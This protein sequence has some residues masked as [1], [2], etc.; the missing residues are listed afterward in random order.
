MTIPNIIHFLFFGFTDFE[1]FHYLAIATAYHVQKPEKI[2]LYNQKEPENN[3]YW[4]AIKPY[5][6]LIKI[7]PPTDFRGIKLESYQYKADIVRM[8]KLLEH[9]GIYLDIDVMV[10][11][12]FHHLLEHSC[13]VGAES[14]PSDTTNI[15]EIGSI[16]NAVLMCEPEHPFIQRWYDS[17]ADNI[18]GKCWA[19]HAVC[20]PKVI[21]S[22]NS[23]GV[24]S[25]EVHIEP[26]RSFMPFCFRDNY[27]FRSDCKFRKDE[28][29]DSYTIHLW[30]TI[31]I[32]SNLKQLNPEWLKDNDCIFSDL[33]LEYCSTL[34]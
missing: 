19:Y 30:E 15:Q 34:E 12:P 32:N 20:L 22:E 17:I 8:E 11:K 29:K 27:I 3:K 23:D 10:L 2:Y 4:G 5:V 13:V 26:K 6:E 25:E 18:V 21:L 14:G 1:F 9:G 31:W 24:R 16:T 33:F 7:T 28:L